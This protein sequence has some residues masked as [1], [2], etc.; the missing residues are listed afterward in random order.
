MRNITAII[1]ILMISATSAFSDDAFFPARRGMVLLTANLN[2]NGRVE[3]YN[4]MTIKNVSASGSNITVSFTVQVLDRNRRPVGSSGE[5]EYRVNISDGTLIYRFESMMDPFFTAKGMN[6]T[7]TA[8]NLQIPSN[9]APGRRLENTWMKI[10]VAVPVVGTVTAETTITNQVCTAIE[11]VTVPAGTFEA[12]KVTQTS[13][14]T[15]TGWPTPTI[16]NTGAA[17]YVRGVGVVKSI[18]YDA[19]GRA[20]SSS[21]LYELLN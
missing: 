14:T 6:Y 21:E 18:T 7:M 13:T 5:K 12:Y 19:R 16:V 3:S 15:T 11:T 9:L 1:I 4:R 2:A 10:N 20:E 17:W 8:G